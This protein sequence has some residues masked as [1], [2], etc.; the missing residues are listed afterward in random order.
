MNRVKFIKYSVLICLL[1]GSNFNI[2]AN[3]DRDVNSVG[4]ISDELLIKEAF[5]NGEIESSLY[6][7]YRFIAH[8]APEE[9]PEEYLDYLPYETTDYG[10]SSS[11]AR[12]MCGYW[13]NLSKVERGMLNRFF[14]P[15]K[16]GY[17]AEYTKLTEEILA[18]KK[19]FGQK[20]PFIYITEKNKAR[21]H[22]DFTS[23]FYTGFRED[24]VVHRT[25]NFHYETPC[26]W[27]FNSNPE[28]K[29]ITIR[30]KKD[31]PNCEIGE[32]FIGLKDEFYDPSMRDYLS[33]K[34]E[35][36]T[37]NELPYELIIYKRDN[38]KPEFE[39]PIYTV[40]I[41]SVNEE[42]MVLEYEGENITLEVGESWS[43]IKESNPP[44]TLITDIEITYY[45]MMTLEIAAPLLHNAF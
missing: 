1:I 3:G 42:E 4:L 2:S 33:G 10:A 8:F 25:D 21:N 41:E 28:R 36:K 22:E 20:I 5:N 39:G 27:S 35:L 44:F 16:G 13:Q 29:T 18:K 32:V 30:A 37:V 17:F 23:P 38:Y 7:V 43:T 40:N 9:L 31:K 45:G 14:I 11:L 15:K 6:H 34:R 19:A 12:S 26:S 24:I